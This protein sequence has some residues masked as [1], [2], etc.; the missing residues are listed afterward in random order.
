MTDDEAARVLHAVGAVS[1]RARLMRTAEGWPAVLGLAAMSGDVDFTSSRLMSHTLYEFLAGELLAAAAEETQDALMLLAVAAI[2]DL[3]VAHS[4]LGA[5]ADAVLEDAV[6]RGLVALTDHESLS[7]HPLLRELLIRRFEEADAETR[8]TQLLRARRLFDLRRWDEALSVS[9]IAND[10]TFATEAVE[11]ALDDLL[12]AG[13]TSSLQRWVAAARAAGAV[14]GLI[15]YVESEARFRAD[16]LD[17]AMA[18]A[19]QATRSLDQDLAARSHL[20]A[21]RA[22]HLTDRRQ[23]AEEHAES[24]VD[25]AKTQETRE[26]ALWLRFTVGFP[27]ET[28]DLR[29]RLDE[30]RRTAR[31]GI[32]QSLH[33]AAGGLSLAELEGNLS[34]AIDS[35][36]AALS[37]AE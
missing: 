33:L 27:I 28:D 16:E 32:T 24:A 9:E 15:D 26:G 25:L 18:L 31:P 29:D 5:N 36:R 10:P 34:Q 23:L 30:F 11:A 35:A 22:A 1:G 21:G 14:G 7:L 4:V 17:A 8:E 6:A 20:V 37:I 3:G 19:T 2:T 13:R 12:A